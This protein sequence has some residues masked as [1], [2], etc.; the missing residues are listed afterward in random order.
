MAMYKINDPDFSAV[1]CI[2]SGQVCAYGQGLTVLQ[3]FGPHYSAPVACSIRLTAGA[4][5]ANSTRISKTA[6]WTHELS[7]GGRTVSTVTDFA[8]GTV[9]VRKIKGNTRL[10]FEVK[11]EKSAGWKRLSKTLLDTPHAFWTHVPEGTSFY[12]IDGAGRKCVLPAPVYA[13]LLLLGDAAPVSGE[14]ECIAASVTDGALAVVFGGTFEELM[15][16]CA[17]ICGEGTAFLYDKAV[18]DGRRFTA[19]RRANRPIDNAAFEAAAD[20]VAQLIKCQQSATGGVLA[21]HAYHL[22]Y[23]RDNYGVHKGL[24]ALGCFDEAKALLLFYLRIFTVYGT[25]HNAQGT[26][27]FAFHIHENDGT[28]ITGYIILMCLEYFRATGD[29]KTFLSLLPL[30]RWAFLEQHTL[31]KNGMLPFN[32]DETYIAGGL[33]PRT[34]LGDGSMEATALYH[35]ACAGLLEYR[36]ILKLTEGEAAML[37][38]DMHKIEDSFERHF[39]VGGKLYANCPGEDTPGQ[40]R[41][42]SGV[43][44]CGHGMGV[45]ACKNPQGVYVCPDCADKLLPGIEK[46]KNIRYDVPSAV[47]MPLAAGAPLMLKK[48]VEINVLKMLKTFLSAGTLTKERPDKTVGYECGELLFAL[49]FFGIGTED[50]FAEITARMLAVRDEAGAWVEYYRYNKPEGCRC[51]PWESGI[52]IAAL[53]G[54]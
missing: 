50:D 23:I 34:V 17:K 2:G 11:N 45:C 42:G 27:A 22:A 32:G 7:E 39:L 37:S 43:Y 18:E 49:R 54:G 21:G 30:M 16:A 5:E 48:A 4:A 14:P 53:L 38:D 35:H 36:N 19:R 24:L 26:D 28:E 41:F 13:C 8:A 1:H 33:L 52:N 44:L 20:D 47:L 40:A 6:V 3:L 9:F 51:R 46:Q 31:L 12:N 15:T 25:L 10:V 29:K